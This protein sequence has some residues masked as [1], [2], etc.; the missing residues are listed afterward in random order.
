MMVRPSVLTPGPHRNNRV[1]RVH[2]FLL[3]LAAGAGT[4][5]TVMF[6]PRVSFT[7]LTDTVGRG[8]FRLL[9]GQWTDDA[10]MVLYL[11]ASR[12][13]SGFDTTAAL[14]G[15]FASQFYGEAQILTACF[16]ML[17]MEKENGQLAEQLARLQIGENES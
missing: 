3:R 8:P 5:T 7:P 11:A 17:P 2:G 16:H 9:P 10:S 4:C 15:Q 13:Q 12:V 6:R 14:A 1:E